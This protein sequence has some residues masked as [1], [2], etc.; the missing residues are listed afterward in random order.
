VRTILLIYGLFLQLACFAQFDY[1][2]Q[3]SWFRL[4]KAVDSVKKADVFFIHP[5]TYYRARPINEPVVRP[6]TKK[7]LE[8]VNWNQANAF[9]HDCRVFM[10]HYRQSNLASFLK[11]DSA[12][13]HKALDT[14]YSDVRNAFIHYLE[15]WNGQ[16]PL[17]IAAHS[18]GSHHAIRLLEEFLDTGKYSKELVVA[19][20]VGFPLSAQQISGLNNLKYCNSPTQ[21]GCVLNWMTVDDRSNLQEPRSGM[22]I[23]VS[24]EMRSTSELEVLCTN[25]ISWLTDNSW[26]ESKSNRSLLPQT[27]EK[28]SRWSSNPLRAKVK[29]AFVRVEGHERSIFNGTYGNLHIYDYNLFYG[30]I[31]L[32]VTERIDTYLERVSD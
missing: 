16:R 22:F 15:Q 24:G 10:P 18:Q 9:E 12:V 30:D 23:N 3:A 25:P 28:T 26:E 7:R 20:L 27:I 14:A 4:P 6:T 21:T 32:N 1:E 31:Q 2:L 5:T 11:G 17:V 13:L 8:I 19:Y 29:G